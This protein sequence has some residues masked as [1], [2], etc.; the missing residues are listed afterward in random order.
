M[1]Y[2]FFIGGKVISLLCYREK[3]I[4]EERLPVNKNFEQKFINKLKII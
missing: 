4:E 2:S 3:L 1:R